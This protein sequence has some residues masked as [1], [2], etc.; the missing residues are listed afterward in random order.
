MH[1]FGQVGGLQLRPAEP[2]PQDIATFLD[3]ATE[4]AVLVS[5]GAALKES[6]MSEEKTR[7]FVEAFS[8]LALPVL[9]KW[10]GNIPGLPSHVLVRSE[11][12][13]N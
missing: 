3:D 2:L 7:V 4:G 8:Q 10:E 5:F 11:Q 13:H 1:S 12:L 6:E 9:W